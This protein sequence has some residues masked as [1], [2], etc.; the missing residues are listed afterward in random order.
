LSF[1]LPTNSPDEPDLFNACAR[2]GAAL[3]VPER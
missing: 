1:Q 3:I 2:I